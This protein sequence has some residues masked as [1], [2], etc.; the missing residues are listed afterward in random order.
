M[1]DST[2]V[3]YT[4]LS[5]SSTLSRVRGFTVELL[6]HLRDGALR[7]YGLCEL[8]QKTH[9]Y[10]SAYLKNMRRYGLVEKNDSFWNLTVLGR[11]F[12]SYLEREGKYNNII[13][14]KE[15]RK[16]K[17]N[18]KKEESSQRKF[19]KQVSI[20]SWLQDSSPDET[21]RVVVEVLLDHYN[22]TKGKFIYASSIYDLAERFGVNPS[23]LPDA[24]RKLHEDQVIYQWP[25]HPR[26]GEH[27]KVG[28]KKDF[29]RKLEES[30][31]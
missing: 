22:K 14:K 23:L 16:K 2:K 1:K 29:I 6:F 10:V 9:Q 4:L 11:D 12:S 17:D 8:T 13:Q 28:L 30:Q 7:T 18:R 25:L 3:N 15:E 27:F 21:E 20:Q 26:P 19:L 5:T 31:K 24:M